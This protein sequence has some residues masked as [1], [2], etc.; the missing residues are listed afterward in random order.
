MSYLMILE[1][2]DAMTQVKIGH[3]IL[4]I[5][6]PSP[7]EKTRDPIHDSASSILYPRAIAAKIP[8][9]GGEGEA[10]GCPRCGGK[11]RGM[12]W[13]IRFDFRHC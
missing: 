4:K 10:G 12:D 7:R 1:S 11:V 9:D 8:A 3:E 6:I 5:T 13:K 2:L